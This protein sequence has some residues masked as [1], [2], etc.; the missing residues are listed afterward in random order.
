MA[1]TLVVSAPNDLDT[2]RHRPPCG[3]RRAWIRLDDHEM[4]HLVDRT[5]EPLATG[6]GWR[7]W[8]TSEGN[9][10]RPVG[11]ADTLTKLLAPFAQRFP[12]KPWVLLQDITPLEV[13]TAFEPLEQIDEIVI[14]GTWTRQ[15][16]LSGQRFLY[17]EYGIRGTP[18]RIVLYECDGEDDMDREALF[19][20]GDLYEVDTVEDRHFDRYPNEQEA[21]AALEPYLLHAHVVNGRLKQRRTG[22]AHRDDLI[23]HVW[24][25]GTGK[26]DPPP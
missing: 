25:S 13:A 3:D 24:W 2:W 9:R 5:D 15:T 4:L 18:G 14:D 21:L 7:A 22:D 11:R 1:F 12:E 16:G 17:P 10:R 19:R 20:L 6:P 26:P 23:A 8:I